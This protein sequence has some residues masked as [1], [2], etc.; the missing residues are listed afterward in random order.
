MPNVL[1]RRDD[2]SLAVKGRLKPGITTVQ[3]QADLTSLA[4]ALERTCRATNRN[5]KARVETELQLR[6]EQDPPDAQLIAMLM[7]LAI[8][9]LLIACSN[10]AGLLLSRARARS[11]E[12]AVRLAIGAGR[13]RLIQQLL[14]ESLLIALMGGALGI[15][16][17]SMG[18]QFFNQIQVPSDLPIVLAAQLDHR[19][20]Y[21]TLLISVFSTIL[22]GLAPALRSTRP[23]L[24]PALKA[25]DADLVERTRL[26]G[27][28]LLVMG[29][30]AYRSYSSRSR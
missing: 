4:A 3:A 7:T 29:Q 2:R 1:E 11:R 9:V 22:F 12:I 30:V 21:F 8:C 16:I 27:R 10:V 20:L 17:A 19:A 15:L 24:V 28:N 6:I 26:W 23:D 5:Q 14:V 18:V 13:M 25:A